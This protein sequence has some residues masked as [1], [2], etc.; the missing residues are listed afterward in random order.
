MSGEPE[1][2]ICQKTTGVTRNSSVIAAAACEELRRKAMRAKSQRR[3]PRGY[4]ERLQRYF[5]NID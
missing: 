2:E 1:A 4:E 3:A 5:E